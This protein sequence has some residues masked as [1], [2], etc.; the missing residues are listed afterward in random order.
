MMDRQQEIRVQT[1]G[2]GDAPEQAGSRLA[3]GHEHPRLGKTFTLQF[4]LDPLCKTQIEDE[5]RDIAGADRA[6]RF[7]GVTDIQ[8]DFEFRGIAWIR[9]RFQRG[10]VD[11]VRPQSGK[12]YMMGLWRGDVLWRLAVP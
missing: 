3:F 5:L 9:D 1:V 7:G 6:F 10:R 2:S 12:P 4:L 11:A 8:D